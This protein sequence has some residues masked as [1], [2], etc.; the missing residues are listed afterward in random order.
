VSFCQ[1]YTY[2]GEWFGYKRYTPYVSATIKKDA[3]KVNVV[4]EIDS[5]AS[6]SLLPHSFAEMLDIDLESGEKIGLVGV[7]GKSIDAYVH[8]L[9]IEFG[10]VLLTDIPVAFAS[11]DVAIPALLGR[12]GVYER[13][14]IL[15]DNINDYHAPAACIG[16]SVK[17][18]PSVYQAETT[19]VGG[20]LFFLL[21]VVTILYW[22]E[23]SG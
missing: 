18:S 10:D 22:G 12:L 5:G 23:R 11:T 4:M 16:D 6:V 3:Q 9:D 8:R 21:C 14:D 15:M 2:D 1:E 17:P 19:S 13:M 20:A 7:G